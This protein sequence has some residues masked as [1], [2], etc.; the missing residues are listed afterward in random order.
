MQIQLHE[1]HKNGIEHTRGK[2]KY[3]FEPYDE[4]SCVCEVEDPEDIAF[5]LKQTTPDGSPIW[6]VLGEER[7]KVPDSS[8]PAKDGLPADGYDDMTFDELSA[9]H[10]HKFGV[11]ADEEMSLD[12]LVAKLREHDAA[13]A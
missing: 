9:A 10:K 13:R 5:F 7:V 3:K 4:E 2:N 1:F 12:D 8:T 11:E 6:T